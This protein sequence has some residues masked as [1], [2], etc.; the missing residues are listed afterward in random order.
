MELL[1]A[2]DASLQQLATRMEVFATRDMV[3]EEVA[4]VRGE[5]QGVASQLATDLA[6]KEV[7]MKLREAQ[8][9]AQQQ[10][11]ALTGMMACKMDKVDMV[12]LDAAATAV[13]DFA[14]FR[15]AVTDTTTRLKMETSALRSGL[16]EQV[17]SLTRMSAVA[18]ATK[19]ALRT[20]AEKSTTDRLDRDMHALLQ[21]LQGRVD[22][23]SFGTL[24]RTAERLTMDVQTLQEAVAAEASSRVTLQE[25][26][27][28]ELRTKAAATEVA[29]KAELAAEHQAV[30]TLEAAVATKGS[31][32]GVATAL[33]RIDDLAKAHIDTQSKVGIALRFVDWYSRKGEAFQT[34]A[35]VV[36]QHMDKLA[37]LSEVG[38]FPMGGSPYRG[39][40]PSGPA[41]SGAGLGVPSS[42]GTSTRTPFSTGAP[43]TAS[44][45]T[46]PL[47]HRA[48]GPYRP[49][50][51]A[52]TSGGGPAT[53]GTFT[54]FTVTGASSTPFMA[55]GGGAGWH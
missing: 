51:S 9:V 27:T 32:E 36:E 8:D 43:G 2:H 55:R 33:A 42:T 14:Q 11:H 41:S 38:V 39:T 52:H 31:A 10:V 23:A 49:P 18:E 5:V 30:S 24:V 3:Q 6:S 12:R 46:T 1:R 22:V 4:G 26:L 7:V 45:A 20:K 19:A 13:R 50:P 29:T 21:S 37:G 28:S 15:D 16:E 34:V 25:Q 40:G 35:D 44:A 48:G 53:G 54:P 47:M 17:D